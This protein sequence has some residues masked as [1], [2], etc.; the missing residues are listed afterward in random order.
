M[1]TIAI[2]IAIIDQKCQGG[3]VASN[4]RRLRRLTDYRILK[5]QGHPLVP[6]MMDSDRLLGPGEWSCIVH[7]V[8]QGIN[9]SHGYWFDS[10]PAMLKVPWHEN[11]TL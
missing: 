1:V 2:F 9:T 11:V 7:L 6:P 5:G 4:G 8:E 3:A 10:P